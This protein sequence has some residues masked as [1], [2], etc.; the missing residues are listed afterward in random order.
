MHKLLVMR[1]TPRQKCLAGCVICRLDIWHEQFNVGVAFSDL[2]VCVCV[3]V[4][5]T[6]YLLNLEQGPKTTTKSKIKSYSQTQH[7]VDD[8]SIKFTIEAL[9]WLVN[10]LHKIYADLVFLGLMKLSTN[11]LWKQKQKQIDSQQSAP[12]AQP[13]KMS[14]FMSLLEPIR[15]STY[16]K[17][18]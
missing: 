8:F 16:I 18:A 10:I 7:G 9:Y 14:I 1:F 6:H 11:T 2:S 3:Y 13:M 17:I 15:H 5:A 12:Q 4:F